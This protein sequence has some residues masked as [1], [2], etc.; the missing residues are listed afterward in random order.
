MRRHSDLAHADVM[1]LAS[2]ALACGA[3]FSFSGP[4]RT[5]L[6]S[7]RPMIAVSARSSGVGSMLT[8]FFRD[9]PVRNWDEAADTDRLRADADKLFDL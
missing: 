3:D 7:T 8:A 2:R 6:R 9:K 1:H 4:R 5:M